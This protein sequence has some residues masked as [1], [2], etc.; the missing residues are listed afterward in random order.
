MSACRLV[1]GSGNDP[2]LQ[3]VYSGLMGV[4]MASDAACNGVPKVNGAGAGGPCAT[5]TT[6]GFCCVDATI[7]CFTPNAGKSCRHTSKC[8]PGTIVGGACP[9][10]GNSVVCCERA[11]V[12]AP[13]TTATTRTQPVVTTT[14]TG[15][16]SFRTFTPPPTL[17]TDFVGTLPPPT[18]MLSIVDESPTVTALST[19]PQ[20]A[21]SDAS[22]VIIASAVS[23]AVLVLLVVAVILVLV[24]RKHTEISASQVQPRSRANSAPAVDVGVPGYSRAAPEQLYDKVEP[25]PSNST[26][27]D[28][29]PDTNTS[30]REPASTKYTELRVAPTP[31]VNLSVFEDT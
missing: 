9:Y 3:P 23:V 1:A 12:V 7:E 25:L 14:T 5:A 18:P 15:G 22:V 17:L 29:V 4:C 20:S 8:K 30:E 28:K 10:F 27:Y 11:T 19:V 24:W 31:Y 6:T 13:T 16:A 21:S 26:M 2:L